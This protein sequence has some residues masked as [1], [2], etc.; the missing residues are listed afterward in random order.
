MKKEKG[1]GLEDKL[2]LWW[3]FMKGSL[4]IWVGMDMGDGYGINIVII[5]DIY[6][7][8]SFMVK[9]YLFKEKE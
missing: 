1:M 8:I 3:I 6:G 7:R 5:K 2:I 9:G 4:I